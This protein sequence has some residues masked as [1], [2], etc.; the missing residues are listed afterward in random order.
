MQRHGHSDGAFTAF[1]LRP[2]AWRREIAQI[3]N[4]SLV[5]SST[6]LSIQCMGIY[7]DAL[8][9]AW[10]ISSFGGHLLSNTFV[11]L[12]ARPLIGCR[13]PPGPEVRTRSCTRTALNNPTGFAYLRSG[14][15]VSHRTPLH[16]RRGVRRSEASRQPFSSQLRQIF[17]FGPRSRK[18]A[19][20]SSTSF[21]SD[22]THDGSY[23]D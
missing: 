7:V 3:G 12:A 14:T 5:Y 4:K 18:H 15:C 23:Y 10:T 22:T 1:W 11:T 19:A 16:C 6:Y 2:S 20:V 9:S 8:H 21:L 17:D 13:R